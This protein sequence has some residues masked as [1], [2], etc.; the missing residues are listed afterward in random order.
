MSITV[1]RRFRTYHRL[2]GEFHDARDVI[3]IVDSSSSITTDPPGNDSDPFYCME[4]NRLGLKVDPVFP[5]RFYSGG[6]LDLYQLPLPA[7]LGQP[8]IFPKSS[9]SSQTNELP[10][11]G[12]IGGCG[13][14]LR[15]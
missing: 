3:A 14:T 4:E 6:H 15:L 2:T 12:L 10:F 1:R 7:M 5:P 9:R 8:C 13:A 11:F